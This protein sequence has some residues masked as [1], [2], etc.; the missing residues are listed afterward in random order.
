MKRGIDLISALL[1]LP[2]L[3]PFLLLV[4]IAIRLD[5]PGPALFRQMRV[6]VGGRPFR[7]VKFRTM[8]HRADGEADIGAAVTR[9][10]D[11]RITRLGQWL[12]R[13]RIDE[14][15]QIFN[16]IAGDMSWIGPRPEAMSLSEW[17][18][19]EIPFYLYRHIVRPGITGWAQVN[20][21]HVTDIAEIDLKL[22]YDFYYIKNFSAWIDILIAIRTVRIIFSG[23][24]TK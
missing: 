19:A 23:F 21:G 13:T 7:I 17:Y 22:Q 16:I 9:N 6:G 24:G 15:P 2:I 10:E 4:G 20:P 1:L 12:R 14:L 8:R 5:S 11:D 3:A 18:D